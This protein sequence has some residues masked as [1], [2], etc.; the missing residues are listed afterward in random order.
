[1]YNRQRSG[2][3]YKIRIRIEA[4][5]V[6]LLICIT[7]NSPGDVVLDNVNMVIMGLGKKLDQMFGL[8]LWRQHF[9]SDTRKLIS[10]VSSLK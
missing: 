8:L 6:L 5:Q 4:L 7:E 2:S 10:K 3:G 9:L 1:M